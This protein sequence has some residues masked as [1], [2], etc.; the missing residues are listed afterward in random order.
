MA[1]ENTCVNIRVYG[2]STVHKI[3]K[4]RE[5]FP[6]YIVHIFVRIAYNK[7]MRWGKKLKNEQRFVSYSSG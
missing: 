7:K 6:K 4:P 3:R 5:R 1:N 2:G